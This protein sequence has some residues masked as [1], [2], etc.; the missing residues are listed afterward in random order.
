MP[1]VSAQHLE[2]RRAQILEAAWRCFVRDGFHGTTMADVIAESGLSAGAVYRYYTGKEDLVRAT[3]ERA[4]GS[5]GTAIDQIVDEGEPDLVQA[6]GR[7]ITVLRT[8]WEGETD[9]SRV[10]L[11]AWAESLQSESLRA[12]AAGGQR[13]VLDRFVR[14]VSR[15]REAGTIAPDADP[16]AVAQVLLGLVLGL[17]VQRLVLGDVP[18]DTYVQALGALRGAGLAPA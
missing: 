17:V 13:A 1:R 4:V 6:L 16:E 8:F 11:M 14:L 5:T 9:V 10:A 12:V 15:A 2:A 3:V 18:T 7:V